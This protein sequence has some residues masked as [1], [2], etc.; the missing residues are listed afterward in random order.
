[1]KLNPNLKHAFRFNA[2]FS[3]LCALT[4]MTLSEW[5]AVQ[6]GLQDDLY[7]QIGAAGLII[8]AI[9]LGWLSL[10]SQQPKSSIIGVIVSDWGYVL[11]AVVGGILAFNMI[12]VEALLF[13][14]LTSLVVS[15][16]A[17]WQRRAAFL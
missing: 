13:L 16:A 8:F 11:A 12:S 2:L 17:E 15:V 4:L 7:V 10:T 6:F 3:T 5:W 14:G 1:M 9:Y